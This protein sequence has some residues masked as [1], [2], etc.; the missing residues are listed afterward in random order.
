[1][2]IKEAEDVVRKV[3]PLMLT[4][5]LLMRGD[6]AI[7][8]LGHALLDENVKYV[9]PNWIKTAKDLLGYLFSPQIEWTQT[10]TKEQFPLREKLLGFIQNGPT[11]D[12]DLDI[13]GLSNE[14][15]VET[16]LVKMLVE[17]YDNLH[18]YSGLQPR[19]AGFQVMWTRESEFLDP[20][21]C[22]Y[23]MQMDFKTPSEMEDIVARQKKARA[24]EI[25]NYDE[26]DE[27]DE[28]NGLKSPSGYDVLFGALAMNYDR[29]PNESNEENP[30]REAKNVSSQDQSMPIVRPYYS[31]SKDY[32]TSS[33]LDFDDSL[34]LDELLKLRI[35]LDEQ[36]A[37]LEYL[38][39]KIA[40][41]QIAEYDFALQEDRISDMISEI[42]D[43][44]DNMIESPSKA[45]LS[46]ARALLLRICNLEE[47][48]LC[49]E[50]EV[51]QLNN[52]IALMEM[53]VVGIREL[54]DDIE[55]VFSKYN[56]QSGFD[57]ADYVDIDDY[58]DEFDSSDESDFD[59]MDGYEDYYEG[60][61][62]DEEDDSI[63]A[64]Y[65]GKDGSITTFDSSH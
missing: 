35:Q 49:G 2:V 22:E 18:N 14:W 65:M 23:M 51:G 10:S 25:I 59:D 9:Q 39:D 55:N 53:G 31:K 44:K 33:M 52:D 11:T 8:I 15:V 50:V 41:L 37:K 58:D 13:G 61:E 30:N 5:M 24:T 60:E 62:E 19:R 16:S 4:G 34:D 27:N 29:N 6:K 48:I 32:I 20:D 36:E 3:F 64:S 54:E 56:S 63:V 42:I 47:R 17:M 26:N 40:D 45:G 46:K 28:E 57:F 21:S 12:D 1:L 43:S 7:T 38:R